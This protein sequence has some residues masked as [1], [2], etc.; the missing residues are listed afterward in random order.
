MPHEDHTAVGAAASPNVHDGSAQRQRAMSC[1]QFWTLQIN[2]TFSSSS[3]N[4]TDDGEMRSINGKDG[5]SAHT[6]PYSTRIHKRMLKFLTEIRSKSKK[7]HPPT[8]GREILSIVAEKRT[9]TALIPYMDI[10][11][12]QAQLS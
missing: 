5:L 4:A 3:H 2:I 8:P 1:V 10:N 9:A 12:V 6:S 11:S 7:A